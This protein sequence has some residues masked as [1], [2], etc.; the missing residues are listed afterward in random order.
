MNNLTFEAIDN[1]AVVYYNTVSTGWTSTISDSSLITTVSGT[2]VNYFNTGHCYSSNPSTGLALLEV[3]DILDNTLEELTRINQ[4]YHIWDA[5]FCGCDVL[6]TKMIFAHLPKNVGELGISSQGSGRNVFLLVK[7]YVNGGYKEHVVDLFAS[8]HGKP[9][10]Q[11]VTDD[12]LAPWIPELRYKSSASLVKRLSKEG[13]PSKELFLRDAIA[14]STKYLVTT[15]H[16]TH[17]DARR[18]NPDDAEGK[19]FLEKFGKEVG[20][21]TTLAQLLLDN[22]PIVAEKAQ[23]IAQLVLER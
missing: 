13:R 10:I 17:I 18:I 9:T 7:I 22:D 3:R 4:K 19:K 23:I 8:R 14:L 11:L 20:F 1:G 2:G 16:P 15:I 6:A 21:K 12:L 5:M